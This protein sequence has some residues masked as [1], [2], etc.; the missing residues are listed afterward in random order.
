MLDRFSCRASHICA[1]MAQAEISIDGT[2]L[3]VCHSLGNTRP[4]TVAVWR[5]DLDLSQM[6]VVV[7]L[8][9][10]GCGLHVVMLA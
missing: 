7:C 2:C 5:A 1:E 3:F 6:V 4:A 9:V 8:M 10:V